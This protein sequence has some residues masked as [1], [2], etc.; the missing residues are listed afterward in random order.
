[1]DILEIK[2]SIQLLKQNVDSYSGR[3]KLLTEQLNDYV[4]EFEDQ[5]NTRNINSKAIELLHIVKLATQEKIKNMFEKIVTDALQYIHQDT[6]YQFKLDI[7]RRGTLPTLDFSVKTPEMQE[8]HNIIDCRGGGT[9]D[10]VS[11]ALRFVLLEISKMPGF[12]F[13]DEPEK[14]LDSPETLQKMI[15]FVKE[16]QKE[17]KRQIFWITHKQEVV[18]TVSCPI[19]INKKISTNSKCSAVTEQSKE[20]NITEPTKTKRGRPKK[21]I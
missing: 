4:A 12:L 8:A 11:L 19:I 1:M 7:L 13:L 5:K 14:H 17:T 2:K 15:D 21:N 9:C 6:D 16:M 20:V 3:I 10:I 18:D